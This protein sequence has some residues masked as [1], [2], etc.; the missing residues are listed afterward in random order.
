MFKNLF[1]KLL[2]I[3]FVFFGII[4]VTAGFYKYIFSAVE[5]SAANGSVCGNGNCDIGEYC[6]NCEADCGACVVG[7]NNVR[8][9]L[10]WEALKDLTLEDLEWTKISTRILEPSN[11]V[12]IEG[13]WSAGPFT[14]YNFNDEFQTIILDEYAEIYLPPNFEGTVLSGLVYAVHEASGLMGEGYNKFAEGIASELG[15]TVIRHGESEDDWNELGLLGRGQI[16]GKTFKVAQEL[17][18]CEVN[19]LTTGNFGVA[20]AKVNVMALTLLDKIVEKEGGIG[21][22]DAAL[23]GGSKEGFATWIASAVD[24][25]LKVSMPGGYHLEDLV[26]GLSAYEDNSACAGTGAGGASETDL[27][28]FRNWLVE[29]ESGQA[30]NDIYSVS[31][32]K[33]LLYPEDM[34]IAGDV[35]VEG[36]HDANFYSPGAETYFLENFNERDWRYD[37]KPNEIR[38]P[39]SVNLQG[40]R[41]VVL[42]YALVNGKSVDDIPKIT[43]A[44]A[45]VEGNIFSVSADVSSEPTVVRLWW[46]ESPDRAFDDGSPSA[47]TEVEMTFLENKWVSGDIIPTQGN[48]IGWYVEAEDEIILKNETF[49]RRDASPIKFL[50]EILPKYTC[51]E[52]THPDCQI[53]ECVIDA[54]C[55]DNLYCNGQEI[56]SL[57][58]CNDGTMLN[59]NDG[60]SCTID[61]CNEAIDACDYTPTDSLCDNGLWCDGYEYCEVAS[62]CRP[63][64]VVD[65]NDDVLCTQDSC[66][67]DA[68]ICNYDS[69]GCDCLVDLDCDDANNCTLNECINSTCVT[70]DIIG[71]ICV[72]RDFLPGSIVKTDYSSI[73][74]MLYE[75]KRYVFPHEKVYYSWLDDYSG[76][77]I[78]SQEELQ[79][80][81]LAGNI[82]FKPGS[83]IKITSD[84]KVY[85][86]LDNNEK[87]PGINSYIEWI[88]SEEDAV[89]LFGADW[90]KLVSDV[91]ETLFIH[92][93]LK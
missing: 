55:D 73:V 12:V 4:V 83:L 63:G 49:Q 67:E 38:E 68:D 33:H 65:C 59:C 89:R 1:R 34:L 71:G 50:F 40:R 36:M 48:M 17:N 42:S 51:P 14:T 6:G 64:T 18:T 7:A 52:A 85:L 70:T 88:P 72:S 79:S 87:V 81:P 26:T 80:Y 62:G 78:I 56:C 53:D 9:L 31:K 2:L 46:A 43:S 93:L 44:I 22:G 90:A 24:P 92:Y 76:L 58:I 41:L 47:W 30:Y 45:T 74:Y 84:P 91:H 3:T 28:S 54:D 5:I 10:D 16:T 61:S 25:R 20:L 21:L 66:N 35:G 82:N 77:S 27:V 75:N 13:T 15:V 60:I 32:F 37:R 69:Q 29:S 19:D 23:R 8:E 11:V 57:G 86:V 39:K